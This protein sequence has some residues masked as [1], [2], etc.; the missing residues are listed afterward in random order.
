VGKRKDKA[1]PAGEAPLELTMIDGAPL[2]SFPAPIIAPLRHMLSRL[3]QENQLPASVSIMA[4]LHEEGV[5]YTTTAI[6]ATLAHDVNQRI[7]VIELNWHTPGLAKLLKVEAGAGLAEVLAGSCE[8]DAALITTALPNLLFLPAGELP[9]EQRAITARGPEIVAL[10]DQLKQRFDIVLLDIP[11]ILATSDAIPLAS[12]G[13]AGLLVVRQGVTPKS[14]VQSALDDV[15]H[16]PM[17]GVVL[18]RVK[19]KMP[20]LVQKIIPQE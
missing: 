10:M 1:A 14:K 19:L 7:G 20:R 12:L 5:T 16:L 2:V 15:K 18:N 17:L 9:I 6:G 4:A 8:L 11:A 13:A 3:T